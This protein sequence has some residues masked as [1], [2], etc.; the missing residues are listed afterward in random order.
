MSVF[1]RRRFFIV[2][3]VALEG[4]VY[5]GPGVSLYYISYCA[6][7]NVTREQDSVSIPFTNG[8]LISYFLLRWLWALKTDWPIDLAA[9]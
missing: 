7:Y 9:N 2:Q 8:H 6:L 3:S 5:H 4:D 1:K